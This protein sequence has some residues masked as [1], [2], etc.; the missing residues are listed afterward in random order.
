V[1]VAGVVVGSIDSL[2]V[3]NGG[4]RAAVVLNITKPGFDDF[5]Q[6]ASCTIRP[7][8]F[9]G[10]RFVECTPT[11][12]HPAG[13]NPSPPLLKIKQGPGK[14][15]YLLPAS[16]NV[17]PVDLDLVGNIMRLPF[18]QRLSVLLNEFG[19]SLGARGKDLS[20]AIRDAD[21][22][23]K[24]LDRV[25]SI[26]AGQNKVLAKLAVDGDR[27]LAPLARQRQQFA[28]SFVKENIVNEAT[29][30]RSADFQ[31]NIE[32][33]PQFLRELTPTMN[34]LNN[35]SKQFVPLLDDLH[36]A[37]PSINTLFTQLPA[38]STAGIPAVETLGDAADVGN[39]ALNASLPTA[40]NLLA[41]SKTATPTANNLAALLGSLKKN[42]SIEKLM[43]A[44][45]EGALSTNGYDSTGHY[46]RTEALVDFCSTYYT[47]P[48]SLCWSNFTPSPSRRV[49][50]SRTPDTEPA[51]TTTAV[52]DDKAKQGNQK[53]NSAVRRQKTS[54]AGGTTTT[55][56]SAKPSTD[57]TT[58]DSSGA[59]LSYLLGDDG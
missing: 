30:E 23:L 15:Q 11:Q 27:S 5:R 46:Q 6:D 14:G 55:P 36:G 41:L 7:E 53:L 32:L 48:Q 35:F 37:A 38:F 51:A 40:K 31:K 13:D 44:L 42:G 45:Y 26:L 56:S 20:T 22:A 39:K 59:L 2:Q 21:P 25:L 34:Q 12:P 49:R 47:T 57:T 29:A 17:T 4:H 9:I 33:L 8:S 52:S 16:N 18:R 10:E 19:I 28:D 58:D 24:Q 54:S 3:V 50:L 43:S 1:K